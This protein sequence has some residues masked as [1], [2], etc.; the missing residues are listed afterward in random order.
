[1][2]TIVV[3]EFEGT[4]TPFLRGILIRS[5]LDAGLEFDQ[6]LTLAGR[7]RD[8]LSDV[9]KIDSEKLRSMVSTRLKKVDKDA[10]EL[11]H[12]VAVAPARIQVYSLSG[13]VSAFSRA[14]H[15]RFLQSN[16]IRLDKA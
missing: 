14:R 5:L 2:K 1:M 4:R 16:G 15:T 10:L 7:V 9:A 6:A 11:Y 8:D 13:A 12:Q 3:N